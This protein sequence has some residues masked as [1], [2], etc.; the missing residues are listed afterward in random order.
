LSKSVSKN[1][2]NGYIWWRF[3]KWHNRL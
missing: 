3:Y 1:N 2:P